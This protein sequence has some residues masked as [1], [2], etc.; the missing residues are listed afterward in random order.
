MNT[1]YTLDKVNSD[2]N[3]PFMEVL[4]RGHKTMALKLIKFRPDVTIKNET[5]ET[6]TNLITNLLRQN[7]TDR[8]ANLL[9]VFAMFQLMEKKEKD[10]NNESDWVSLIYNMDPKYLNYTK[11]QTCD[12]PQKSNRIDKVNSDDGNTLFMLALNNGNTNRA[13]E[14]KEF[15]PD[16]TIKNKKNQTA[17][18]LII[19]LLKWNKSN[20][21]TNLLGIFA[22]SQLIQKGVEQVEL[23][24]LIDKM[25]KNLFIRIHV[26]TKVPY[27]CLICSEHCWGNN[28]LAVVPCG[29][30]ACSECLRNVNF[31]FV[32]REPIESKLKVYV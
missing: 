1:I 5:N 21:H 11:K 7:R 10:E 13:L 29:H 3:T 17:T 2:G 18:D 22:V 26:P 9:G 30:V 14:L 23:K 20:H 24:R 16:V 25:D 8:N 27:K 28:P 6:A 31:C 32:C 12:E 19:R 15:N 4:A